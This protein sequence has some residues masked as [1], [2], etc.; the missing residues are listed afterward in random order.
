MIDYSALFP[1][2]FADPRTHTLD[3]ICQNC[4]PDFY[5]DDYDWN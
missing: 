3:C 1:V 5:L 2:T 4:D